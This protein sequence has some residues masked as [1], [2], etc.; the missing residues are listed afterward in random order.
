MRQPET[1]GKYANGQKV[2]VNADRAQ[3]LIIRRYYNRIYYCRTLDDQKE[4]AYF[5]R[6]ISAVPS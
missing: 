5:E 2:F 3:Q 1:V 6:E 4:H